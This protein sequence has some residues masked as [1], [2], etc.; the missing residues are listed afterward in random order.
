MKLEDIQIWILRILGYKIEDINVK[1]NIEF[2][3]NLAKKAHLLS[4][5]ITELFFDKFNY[6]RFIL[7]ILDLI[8]MLI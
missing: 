3:A 5:D 1:E 4:V 6:K 8:F 7:G 2:I